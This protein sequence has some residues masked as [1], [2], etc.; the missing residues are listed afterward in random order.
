MALIRQN[1][2]LAWVGLFLLLL[3]CLPVSAA[4]SLCPAE[5]I[6]IAWHDYEPYAYLNK[7]ESLPSGDDI[8][9]IVNVLDVMGCE[10]RFTYLTWLRTL[11]ELK[12]GNIEIA[13]FAYITPERLM[14]LDFS[15][16][17]RTEKVRLFVLAD[18]ANKWP[19]FNLSELSSYGIR[20]AADK[21]TWYG[22]EFAQA[23]SR[24]HRGQYVHVH[25]TI[26]RVKMLLAGHVKAIVGDPKT[27]RLHSEKMNVL[28]KI[29]EHPYQIYE[30]SVHFALRKN[31][32]SQEFISAFNNELKKA[33]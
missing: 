27:I 10:Y 23:I 33:L 28:E 25:S 32:F 13:P 5:P 3:S 6:T 8:R 30:E 11:S 17:Y 19:I 16:P 18:N 24:D 7:G 15:D 31:Y 4:S 9:L 1:V 26:K 21:H 2:M 12:S 22:D 29:A 20:V 14:F